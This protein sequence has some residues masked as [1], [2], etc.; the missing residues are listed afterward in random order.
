VSVNPFIE[1]FEAP[2]ATLTA[3]AYVLVL[4]GLLAAS[5]WAATRN[6]LWLSDNWQDGWILL[7]PLPYAVRLLALCLLA[8]IDLLL[9]AGIAHV[10]A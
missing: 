10:V 2:V 8:A 6:L 4:L 7:I 9:L 5:W 3:G 1:L